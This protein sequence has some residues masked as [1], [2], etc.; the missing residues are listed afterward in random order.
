M[1]RI[2]GHQLLKR[3]K[4]QFLTTAVGHDKVNVPIFEAAG[5]GCK[6]PLLKT[7]MT[8][9]CKND[10]KFCSLRAEREA[11][12]E[13]WQPEQLANVTMKMWRQHRIRG[14]FLSSSVEKDP[15]TTVEKEIEAV[16]LLRSKGFTDYIH[17][18][19]MPGVDY[20]LIKQGV[21]LADRVGINIEFPHAEHYNDMKLF[22]DFRQ[23]I[24]KRIRLLAR[25]I[26]KAKAEGRCKAGLDSQ[27][28]VGASDET[29]KD[30]LKISEVLYKKLHAHRV[31]YS[32]FEPIMHTPLEN[33]PAEDRWREYRLYQCSF[34]LQKYG[35]AAKEFVL[36]D[37]D[38]LSLGE[39]PKFAIALR[40][41]LYV[42]VN[43]AGFE[44]LVK[45]PGI[46]IETANRILEC[47]GMGAKFNSEDEL[48][49]V[50]V[51]VK[52]AKPFV[53]INSCFQSRMSKFFTGTA[54]HAD[55]S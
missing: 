24:I 20:D 44:E 29:D 1:P 43:D 47:R 33:R 26:D 30:M 31:Y 55:A 25:E 11:R 13:S 19:V 38:M 4:W 5:R 36:D 18:K 3:D 40:S 28:V 21:Q 14:L 45:V 49:K 15:N 12:R 48:R 35:F 50:G 23:D 8:S 2:T 16:Q 27:M 52:R 53:K 42:D 10:C 32:A 34:L 9:K 54:K 22:L 6:V 46:G 37:K 51:I 39:D 7:L 17:L 41:E